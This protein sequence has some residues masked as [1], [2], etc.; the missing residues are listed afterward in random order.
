VAPVTTS[1][2][3]FA[4]AGALLLP[5]ATGIVTGAPEQEKAFTDKYKAAME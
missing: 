3:I 4:A 5:L 1:T 2:K